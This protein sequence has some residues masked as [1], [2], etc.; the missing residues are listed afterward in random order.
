MKQSLFA[1][2]WSSLVDV[3][4]WFEWTPKGQTHFFWG[5]EPFLMIALCELVSKDTYRSSNVVGFLYLRHTNTETRKHTERHVFSRMCKL[6]AAVTLPGFEVRIQ[7]LEAR[8][9]QQGWALDHKEAKSEVADW[10]NLCFRRVSL[11]GGPP[12]WLRCRVGQPDRAP[13]KKTKKHGTLGKK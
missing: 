4:V 7:S 11:K 6:A 13:E 1:R 5:G 2:Y 3:Q 8:L 12:K 9:G 10:R